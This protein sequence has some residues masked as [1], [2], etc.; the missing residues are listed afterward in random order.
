MRLSAKSR[1]GKAA[2]RSETYQVY[3]DAITRKAVDLMGFHIG[4]R[5]FPNR[6]MTATVSVD[7]TDTTYSM[8]PMLKV[9][10]GRKTRNNVKRALLL[11]L[12]ILLF[13]MIFYRFGELATIFTSS[14]TP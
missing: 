5:L 9:P 8:D 4:N 11:G 12:T 13:M 2:V 14:R 7:L 1:K 3:F 6:G 10:E